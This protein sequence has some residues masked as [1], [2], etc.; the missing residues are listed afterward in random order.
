MSINVKYAFALSTEDSKILVKGSAGQMDKYSSEANKIT[1]K[2]IISALKP[3]ERKKIES[4]NHGKWLSLC[5]T[6]EY[7]FTVCVAENY[8]ERI[9]NQ[10]LD[11]TLLIPR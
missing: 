2:L 6:Q 4:P 8:S 3:S 11:V 7:I 5:D 10:F 9:A 1:T